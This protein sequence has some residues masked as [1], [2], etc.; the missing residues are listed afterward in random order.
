MGV[1]LPW[2]RRISMLCQV[3]LHRYCTG[4]LPTGGDCMCRCRHG[5]AGG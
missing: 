3:G 2:A 4:T 5:E 1:W